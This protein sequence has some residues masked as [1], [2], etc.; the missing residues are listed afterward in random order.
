MELIERVYVIEN[1]GRTGA[2]QS[3]CS[4]F[5]NYTNREGLYG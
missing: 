2:L 4:C 1:I 5:I 3:E